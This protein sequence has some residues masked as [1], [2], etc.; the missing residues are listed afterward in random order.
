M[1]SSC[2][3]G[4]SCLL[5]RVSGRRPELLD[6]AG[7]ASLVEVLVYAYDDSGNLVPQTDTPTPFT[8]RP[9]D[10]APCDGMLAAAARCYDPNPGRWLEL[11]PIGFEGGD[12]N[13][14]RYVNTELR[15]SFPSEDGVIRQA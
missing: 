5:P 8:Y 12:A 6:E 14:C 4:I 13:L 11:D 10:Q 7:R 9:L 2:A 3:S 1:K 15:G